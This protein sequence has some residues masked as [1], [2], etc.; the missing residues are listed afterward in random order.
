MNLII[1]N[2]RVDDH[3]RV[4][5][6]TREAFW[7]LHVP[8]CDEHYLVHVMRQH[9]DFIAALDLVAVVDDT[10]VGSI[11]YTRSRLVDEMEQAIDAITFGP[12]SVLPA[13]QRQGIGSRLIR[14]SIDRAVAGGHRVIVIQGY[15]GDYCKHGFISCRDLGICD[16]DG[17]HP[18]ALL[19]L[20]LQTG[21]LSGHRWSFQA[22]DVYD[23][24]G[25][26]SEEFDRS[27]PLREKAHRISQEHFRI[28]C[29]AYLD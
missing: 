26:S 29:R 23:V 14:H 8:G 20:E 10:I 6:L 21:L 27:F 3:R 2:E 22:S 4:E 18:Y 24:D 11:M 13:F 12:V 7:N 16:S 28:A 15:P 17:R 25:E 9:P 1:R 19:A 5:E